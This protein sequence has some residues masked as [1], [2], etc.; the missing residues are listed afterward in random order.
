MA[1]TET[2]S[3]ANTNTSMQQNLQSPTNCKTAAVGNS[4]L[5]REATKKTKRCNFCG[6]LRH[7][8]R[9]LCPTKN[10]LCHGCGKRGHFV[11]IC[12]S[13]LKDSANAL[14]EMQ[15]SAGD[16]K[17]SDV[18]MA[19]LLAGAPTG[20]RSRCNQGQNKWKNSRSFD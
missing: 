20:L 14:V 4:L 11:K 17:Q 18:Y 6:K 8:S 12:H 16:K 7:A 1:V 5:K 2:I 19:T 13:R 9:D 3:S 10:A 15:F